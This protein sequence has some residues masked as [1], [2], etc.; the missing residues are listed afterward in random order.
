[1]VLTSY[2]WKFLNVSIFCVNISRTII[3]SCNLKVFFNCR[4]TDWQTKKSRNYC[5]I[6]IIKIYLHLYF[7]IY[8]TFF[9]QN[10]IVLIRF[11]YFRILLFFNR[12]INWFKMLRRIWGKK[13]TLALCAIWLNICVDLE[14]LNKIL[15]KTWPSV[16]EYINNI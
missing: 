10:F 5:K 14:W 6:F 8:H 15:I 7:L 9:I 11:G 2:I 3:Y 13:K 16:L 4:H 1:M 12:D